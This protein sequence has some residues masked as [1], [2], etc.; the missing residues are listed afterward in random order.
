[1][2]IPFL[3]GAYSRRINKEYNSKEGLKDILNEVITT[4]GK[5]EIGIEKCSNYKQI[6]V[7][8]IQILSEIPKVQAD[9]L[10]L[11]HF[12]EPNI[13]TTIEGIGTIDALADNLWDM[14]KEQILNEKYS[15]NKDPK[16]AIESWS[17]YNKD[18]EKVING[19]EF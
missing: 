12:I 16:T 15:A 18:E 6:D 7:Y 19:K 2:S 5:D 9:W 4:C 11:C 14:Y 8:I 3:V 17:K 1:M 10:R 13:Y